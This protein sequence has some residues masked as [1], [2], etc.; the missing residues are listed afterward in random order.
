MVP[1]PQICSA[2]LLPQGIASD[3]AFHPLAALAANPPLPAIA[4]VPLALLAMIFIAGHVMAMN[5]PTS[6]VPTS[7]KRI[8]SAN[9]VMLMW[10]VALVTY[11]IS[12]LNPEHTSR[13]VLTWLTIITVVGLVLILALLDVLNTIRLHSAARR[14]IREELK[15]GITAALGDHQNSKIKPA[16]TPRLAGTNQTGSNSNP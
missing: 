9:G 2:K 7:R 8:R 4:V 5:D 13:F 16:T 3:D 15:Q 12:I 1:D 11:A 6:G 10:L 14:I